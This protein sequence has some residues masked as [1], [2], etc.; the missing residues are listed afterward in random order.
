[1]FPNRI[2]TRKTLKTGDYSLVG[3]QRFIAAEYKSLVDLCNWV[4][5]TKTKRFTSQMER[6]S[7]LYC[8]VVVVGG[9]LGSIPKQSRMN[10]DTMIRRVVHGL[11]LYGVPIVFTTGRRQAT[12][13]ILEFLD[14]SKKHVD[15]ISYIH[16]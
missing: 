9:R 4:H 16:H 15:A 8:K 11:L 2:S 3:Y 10:E 12:K 1:M 14:Q 5:P 7:K 6:L 13:V